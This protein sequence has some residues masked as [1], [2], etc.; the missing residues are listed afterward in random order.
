M[1]I[2]EVFLYY[3]LAVNL[4]AFVVY[5]VDKQ[6]AIKNKWRIS[7]STLIWLAVIG[8]SIGAMTGMKMWHHKTKHRKFKYGVPAIFIAQIA[9]AI[10]LGYY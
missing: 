9:V 8:G 4:I 2:N 5:G 10:F 7:E 1:E 6:R 3:F